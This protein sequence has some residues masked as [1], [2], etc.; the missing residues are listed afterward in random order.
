[1]KSR[2]SKRAGAKRTSKD[3]NRAGADG[4]SELDRRIADAYPLETIRAIASRHGFNGDDA[5]WHWAIR[6][7]AR[8][9]LVRRQ[10]SRAKSSASRK[11]SPLD[12]IAKPARNLLTKLRADPEIGSD[13]AANLLMLDEER[14]KRLLS[15]EEFLRVER[16]YADSVEMLSLMVAAVEHHARNRLPGKR[17]PKTDE[18]LYS[19]IEYLREFWRWTLGRRFTVDYHKG[20]GLSHAYLFIEDA[21]APLDK[22]SSV[23][24]VNMMRRVIAEFSHRV[25]D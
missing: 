10:W 24:I 14:L 25:S 6:K 3:Q 4:A 2:V 13:L 16:F 18:A 11:S 22:V 12:K 9:Y 5:Q 23:R 7:A 17:G 19:F 15:R 1:M 20:A 21:I 8:L